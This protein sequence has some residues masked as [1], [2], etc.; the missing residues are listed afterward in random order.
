M[1]GRRVS[2][3]D[4]ARESGVSIT[5]VSHALNDKGR[6]NPET[7]ERVREVAGRLGYRPNPAA[8]SLVSGRTGLIAVLTSLPSGVHAEM[9]DFGYFAD[10]VGAATGV[11]MSHDVALV[12]APWV[13]PGGEGEPFVWDRVALDG[14]IVTSPMVGDTA[15]PT[16][17]DRKIPFVTVG[18]D[19]AGHDRDAVVAIDD[20]AATR[21]ML[22]HLR[23]AGASRPGL[24]VLPPLFAATVD[25]A[26]A[27]RTWC[28]DHDVA[29]SSVVVEIQ[30]L[31]DD[32]HATI[33]K[34]VAELLDGP[35]PVDAIYC[36]V[37]QIG[38]VVLEVL[39]GRGIDVPADVMLA[40]TNDAG[41]A[42]VAPVPITTLDTD[43]REV[44]TMA[45][46]VL[47]DV[48]VGD[49]EPPFVEVV[50]TTISAR[51]STMRT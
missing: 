29:P 41:R 31:L 36:P 14:V 3:R 17:R 47:L 5:T 1:G 24:I 15:L 45:V 39:R 9:G 30:D 42:D 37:E 27:Y 34:A 50:P 8:R 49:R 32:R 2:I 44:G 19:P 6:L 33:G 46:E 51:A 25:T 23:Q 10:L 40:T 28:R 12:V 26:A 48:V 16:L 43:H 21:S 18:P 35:Q 20:L 38:V 4:V 7:R 22:D 11:A 13:A